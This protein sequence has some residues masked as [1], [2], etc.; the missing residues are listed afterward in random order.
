VLIPL[1]AYD[2]KLLSA[3]AEKED[4]EALTQNAEAF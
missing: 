2:W 1:A 4:S 3:S